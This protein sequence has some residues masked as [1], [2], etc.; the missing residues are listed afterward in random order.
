MTPIEVPGLL[1]FTISIV[2]FF[3]GAHLNR[4][5][6]ILGRWTIPE[7]VTG[8]LLASTATLAAYELLDV[9]I[10]FTLEARDLLLLYFFTGV[11]LNARVKDL[12]GSGRPFLVLLS[13]T[14]CFL[15]IQNVIAIA[16]A[17]TLGLPEGMSI[18]LG[19]ASLIGGHGTTIA[20]APLISAR[21]G[22]NNAL[23]VGIASSTLGLV[24]ASLIGGPIGRLLITRHGL[25][26]ATDE[27]LTIGLSAA[28]REDDDVSYVSLL[29]TLLVMNIAIIVGYAVYEV[30]DGAGVKLPLFVAC[31]LVAICLTNTIPYL[32]PRLP[33][34]TRSRALS[35]L[36]D[37]SLNVFL[38]MSLMSMQLWVLEGLGFSLLV[39]L[40][41]QTAATILF[42][43]LAVFPAM[44]RDYEAAVLSAG[45]G[46][47]ALGATPTAIANMTAVTKVYGAATTA[48]IILPLISA[49]FIDLANAAVI[50]FLAR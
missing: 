46:G 47:I 41:L 20:W 1:T 32:L 50:G 14:L 26:G 19:S 43:L 2:V 21:Y 24:I 25:R 11:G 16:S 39:I 8:G 38:A 18:F 33:W 49:F 34:P 29:Q 5:I 30:I 48:F 35:L 10:T 37:L 12:I 17:A 9:E 15:V 22:L 7:A 13:L 44:G 28:V 3:I 23:E 31:L 42:I 40:A 4:I 36:S 6:P 27:D 45:F